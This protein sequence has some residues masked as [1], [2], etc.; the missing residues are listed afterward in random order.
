[1]PQTSFQVK[2]SE[3]LSEKTSLLDV[4]A[5]VKLSFFCGLL[6]ADGSAK[7]L[8][9]KTS[10]THQ[11]SVT[12]NYHVTTKF[13]QLIISELQSPN[14]E[15]FKMTDATHVV[16]GITYGADALMEFQ[17]TASD[18]S[19]KQEIQGNLN[20]MIKKI[21]TIEISG[22]GSLNMDDEDKEKVK[23]MNCKF[24]GDFQLKEIPSTYEQAVK[25][26]KDLP[27]LLGEKGENA[28]PVKVWLF[29]LSKLSKTESKLKKM[30][31]DVLLSE[32]ENVMDAFHQAEIRSNDLL[33]SSKQFKVE[34]IIHKLEQFQSKLKVFSTEFLQKMAD[35][36]PAIREGN[37]SET[38][39]R[40]LLDSK[41]A[42][43]FS[44]EEMEQWL[45]GKKTE[46]NI[47]EIYIKKM[48]D[49]EIKCPGSELDS[50]LMDPDVSDA[51]VFSFTS[52]NYKEPYLQKISHADEDKS[53]STSSIPE[54]KLR[55]ED[56]WYNRPDAKEALHSLLNVFNN[57]PKVKVISF[58][59][60]PEHPGASIRWYHNAT[61]KDRHVTTYEQ[62]C[63]FPH[64]LCCIKYIASCYF[65]IR[66]SLTIRMWLM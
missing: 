37:M 49:C 28:V 10:S 48:Q 25:L 15:V 7:Y 58:I 52:L 45:D 53:G 55:E 42:S 41:D 50:F 60:D 32:I 57:V 66:H 30:I 29:P 23:N 22:S 20:V 64:N 56:H 63:K 2:A 59:S 44:R 19:S 4:S 17:E 27:S 21:P 40:A 13:E 65:Y 16:I 5:S 8:S 12:L 36:I 54:Q 31:S 51:F 61:L 39:L 18:A 43:G 6:E 33:Q 26:Y 1:M 38:A 62:L 46:I 3:S 11:C 34:I 47:V 14:P 24:Y 35:L 9:A